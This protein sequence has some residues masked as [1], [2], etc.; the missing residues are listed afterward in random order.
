M[1]PEFQRVML[2]V[3]LVGGAIAAIGLGGLL[4][5]FRAFGATRRDGDLMPIVL[6]AAVLLFVIVASLLL[7]RISVA[8]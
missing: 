5:A 1:D 4:I 2:R 7:L 6:T 8:K 3:F